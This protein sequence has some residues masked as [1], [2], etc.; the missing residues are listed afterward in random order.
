MTATEMAEMYLIQRNRIVTWRQ[1]S[2]V[3]TGSQYERL[4]RGA[5]LQDIHHFVRSNGG[6]LE[7]SEVNKIALA[8]E[9]ITYLPSSNQPPFKIGTEED[10]RQLLAVRNGILDLS[11]IEHGQQ[12]DL[13]P[14]SDEFFS[15]GCVNYPYDPAASCPRFEQFL[16]WFACDDKNIV[17]L[18]Q[19]FAGSLLLP[20]PYSKAMWL[21]GPGANGKSVLIS[22]LAGILGQDNVTSLG[23]E[24]LTQRFALANAVHRLLIFVPDADIDMNLPEG[25]LKSLISQDPVRI[26]DKF[27]EPMVVRPRAK[28]IV[29][30]NH[31]PRF[32]DRS[33]GIWRR[34]IL[35]PCNARIADKDAAPRLA[36][37]L[38]EQEGSGILNWCL[39][40]AARLRNRGFFDIPEICNEAL[41][42]ERSLCNSASLFIR[43]QLVAS[44]ESK[45]SKLSREVVL[46]RYQAW[47]TEMGYKPVAWPGFL[48]ELKREFGSIVR[49][50]RPGRR[51]ER[52]PNVITGVK[53]SAADVV[54]ELK[55]RLSEKKD[56][57]G[58]R[59]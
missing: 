58:S 53:W 17:N 32:R 50:A 3:F 10:N 14:S 47:C 9:Q 12:V 24:Q 54:A 7:P 43:E 29:A 13:S 25:R 40:G 8:I 48:E 39:A 46:E 30:S 6:S 37:E 15:T 33:D 34:L 31:A 41:A 27:K 23:L 11:G 42:D 59:K 35:V 4:E 28:I 49:T 57:G 21:H 22:V 16:D 5:L 26:E 36:E 38:V 51:G 1:H 44:D 56:A 55:S 19:D 52:R 20:M 18:L 45:E 2:Y